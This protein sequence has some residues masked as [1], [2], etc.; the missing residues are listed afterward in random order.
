[1]SIDAYS[2]KIDKYITERTSKITS[3]PSK[4]LLAPKQIKKQQEPEDAIEKI[5]EI[6]AAIREKRMQLKEKGVSRG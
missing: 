1:M 3:K 2:K 4:G 6:V 5:A